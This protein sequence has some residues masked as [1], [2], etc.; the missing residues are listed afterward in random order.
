MA[1]AIS[2]PAASTWQARPVAVVPLRPLGVVDAIDAAPAGVSTTGTQ[3]C[4]RPTAADLR[5]DLA[6]TARHNKHSAFVSV[7]A[8]GGTVT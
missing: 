8:F 7:E 2:P 6:K 3:A 4:H 1:T 5:V